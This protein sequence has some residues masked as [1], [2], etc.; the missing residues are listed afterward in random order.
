MVIFY[1]ESPHVVVEAHNQNGP[2]FIRLQL[3]TG[4]WRWFVIGCYLASD[5]TSSIKRISGDTA[6][7][8]VMWHSWW[9]GN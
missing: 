2:N 4:Y 8:P 5:D 6:Q 3:E 1:R 7:R 9:W